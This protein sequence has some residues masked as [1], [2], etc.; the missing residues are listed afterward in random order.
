MISTVIFDLRLFVPV[1]N[2]TLEK[3]NEIKKKVL[4]H[5]QSIAPNGGTQ[6]NRYAIQELVIYD[7]EKEG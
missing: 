2:A 4:E 5:Y 7:R 3:V 1:E 6:I